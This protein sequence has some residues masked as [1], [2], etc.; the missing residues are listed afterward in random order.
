MFRNGDTVAVEGAAKLSKDGV[1]TIDGEDL[2]SCLTRLLG[3]A[4][5]N[6]AK[7]GNV[8][9]TLHGLGGGDNATSAAEEPLFVEET[10]A[11]EGKK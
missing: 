8:R 7:L 10:P 4:V 3:K 1:L 6:G 2:A 9:V 5:K 11:D